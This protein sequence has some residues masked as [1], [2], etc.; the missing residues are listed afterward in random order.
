M[1]ILRHTF[2]LFVAVSVFMSC[3]EEDG[4]EVVPAVLRLTLSGPAKRFCSGIWVSERERE[5]ALYNSVLW[6]EQLVS[7][8]E[9]GKLSF[10]VEESK[11]VVTASREGVSAS[12][13]FFG[14]QGCVILRP[15]TDKPMFVPREVSSSLPDPE[16]TFWPMG[17]KVPEVLPSEIDLDL[18]LKITKLILDI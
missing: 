5:E 8:Y 12:A 16:S 18:L 14:D 9:A 3:Q 1:S 17:D 4:Q 15:E 11:R 6:N 10:K 2:L 7:D 13:R